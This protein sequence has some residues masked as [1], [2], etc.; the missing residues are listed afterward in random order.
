MGSRICSA[1][2]VRPLREVGLRLPLGGCQAVR[3]HRTWLWGWGSTVWMQ[4]TAGAVV[5]CLQTYKETGASVLR[6]LGIQEPLWCHGRAENRV[7][8]SWAGSSPSEWGKGGGAGK[9]S[10]EIR[11]G[12]VGLHCGSPR[13]I[14]MKRGSPWFQGIYCNSGKWMSKTIP[15]LSEWTW[16]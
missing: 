16:D 3:N 6:L 15:H 9:L 1:T 7:V 11:G 8:S 2:G 12:S 4:D 5:W 13:R 10:S 14:P